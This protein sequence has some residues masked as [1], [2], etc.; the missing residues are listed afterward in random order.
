MFL[1]FEKVLFSLIKSVHEAPPPPPEPTARAS[2]LGSTRMEQDPF[3][4]DDIKQKEQVILEKAE[5]MKVSGL[6]LVALMNICMKLESFGVQELNQ[7]I[8][9]CYNFNTGD[10]LFVNN[11]EDEWGQF[12]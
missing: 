9:A 7:L 6:G 4:L 2:L 8:Q 12:D 5:K 10:N 11:F 1:M 3:L